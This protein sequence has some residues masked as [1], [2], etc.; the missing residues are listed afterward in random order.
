MPKRISGL[1]TQAL[2]KLRKL[3]SAMQ[4][5]NGKGVPFSQLLALQHTL[6][7]DSGMTID[8][9]ATEE[10]GAPMV[11]LRVPEVQ[12]RKTKL[13]GLTKRENQIAQLVAD[14]LTNAEIA[15]QLSIAVAT[16]KDHVHSILDKTGLKRRTQ[17]AAALHQ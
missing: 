7:S 9:N 3:V 15:S 11:V 13:D 4:S 17:I 6:K 16:V 14:G 10:L 8:F 5:E 2:I 1:D 12:Q